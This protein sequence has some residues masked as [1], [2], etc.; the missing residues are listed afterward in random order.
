[1]T[2]ETIFSLQSVSKTYAATGFLIAAEKGWFKLDDPLRKHLPQFTVKSRF[3]ADQVDQ[4]TFRHLL[5]HRAG[6]THSAPCGNGY[7]AGFCSFEDHIK[8]ISETWLKFPVG[9][10]SRY[11]NLGIDLVGYAVQ[12]RAGKTFS[13]FM[14]DELF[15]PLGMKATFFNQ[16][17]K[18]SGVS[19]A[20]GHMANVEVPVE[21][22]AMIPAA[23]AYSN[24]NDMAKF[25]SF[26][27]AG[28]SLNGKRLVSEALLKEM[29]TPQFAKIG[30]IG[31]YGLG[32][33]SDP[34]LGGTVLSHDGSGSGF[35]TTQRWMPEY[36]IG[37]VILT[38]S[39]NAGLV[40]GGAGNRALE[41]MIGAKSGGTPVTKPLAPTD[42]PAV[43]VPAS[44]L[45]RFEGT[46]KPRGEMLRFNAREG[47]LYL[48][49]MKLNAHSPSEFT[50]TDKKFVFQL[51][52]KG[53]VEG[54]QVFGTSG[55]G[56]FAPL[57]DS[58]GETAG[59]DTPGW[60]TLVGRY[61]I[62]N[63]G[64][65]V[66]VNVLVKNSY[67]YVAGPIGPLSV[68]RG[69]VKLTEHEPGL[70]FTSEGEAVTFSGDVMLLD[71]RTFTRER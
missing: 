61:R 1:M 8:S 43:A 15:E 25:V 35:A 67:L 36:Q 16:K 10:V 68:V 40:V 51:N 65:T 33:D 7:D 12:L 6:L 45:Q 66:R 42:E 23:G 59:P 38:N 20:K 69:E 9:T 39:G 14:H 5:S 64:L 52:E 2:A 17:R 18:L 50:T 41:L 22:L 56:E 46:Y 54:V 13:E 58:P 26:Q 19:A 37:V 30:Q 4:I 53:H 63:M 29:Y 27:L 28:G 32:L 47:N 48:N 49:A 11:S 62:Q 55:G 34:L 24:V 31:G 3:G 57:N 21:F 44:L 70:F 71:N 60:Q